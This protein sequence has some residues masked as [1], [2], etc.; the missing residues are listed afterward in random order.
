M[1]RIIFLLEEYSMKVF[2]E[3]LLPRVFPELSF[4]CVAHQGKQ[5]LEKSVP[6]KLKVWNEPGARFIVVRDNDGG[7]CVDLKRRL[8]ALC[9]DDK[10]EATRVRIACQELEAW[11]FGDLQ[12]L[13]EV[14][15]DGIERAI[16]GKA[17]FR[18]PDAI[19]HPS[20]ALEQMAPSFQKVGGARALS[21]RLSAERNTS[22][23]FRFF[24]EAVR[25]LMEPDPRETI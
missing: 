5:D 19:D 18:D 2:L 7:D 11:Y 17:R 10:R 22:R 16:K 8:L 3:G 23:S 25:T 21:A 20:R 14:Y 15:G 13:A 1:K 6:R 24:L 12:A 9:P 4:L